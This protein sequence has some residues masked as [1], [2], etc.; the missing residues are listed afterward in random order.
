LWIGLAV[1]GLLII[2]VYSLLESKAE[3]EATAARESEQVDFRRTRDSL[4][5]F[6][7]GA[8]LSLN[9]FLEIRASPFRSILLIAAVR[10]R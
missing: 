10:M 8:I 7:M 2:K 6:S 9:S 1:A 3:A 4:V 5:K